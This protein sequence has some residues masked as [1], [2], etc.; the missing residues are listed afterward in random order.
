MGTPADLVNV[1]FVCASHPPRSRAF[2][3]PSR[4]A[5][6]QI[7]PSLCSTLSLGHA[8]QKLSL[9]L[10][11]SHDPS[12]NVGSNPALLAPDSE[13]TWGAGA[14]VYPV[15]YPCPPARELVCIQWTT[16]A[17]LGTCVYPVDHPCPLG[18]VCVPRGP[19]TPARE[20]MCTL[21]TTHA[22]L[23]YHFRMQNDMKLP[24]SQRRK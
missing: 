13:M 17:H 18:N 7:T 10:T 11:K 9:A 4:Q 12:L 19:P 6:A 21:W 1:R 2:L 5:F 8:T 20:L 3:F 16:H 23:L 14:S 22:C 24:P 15:D